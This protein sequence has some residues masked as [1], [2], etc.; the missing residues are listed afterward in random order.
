MPTPHSRSIDL[1]G[2]R[3]ARGLKPENT[4]PGFEVALD[5]G[6]SSIETD[7]HLTADGVPVLI[8]DPALPDGAPIAGLTLTQLR[9][10]RVNHNPDPQRFAQQDA[11]VTPLA[12]LFAEHHEIDPYAPP[13]VTDLFA[14]TVAYAGALGLQAGKSDPQRSRA[15]EVRFDLE[16]KRVPF[17][18]EYIGDSFQASAAG[19]LE[20]ALLDTIRAAGM[21]DRVRVRSFDHRCVRLLR[22]IEPRLS[23]GVLISGTAP[24]DPAALV[25]QADATR[26]CPDHEFLDEVQVQQCHAAGLLVVPWTVNQEADWQR[27]LAWGVDGLTTDYPDRLAQWLRQRGMGF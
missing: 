12:K 18:P 13:A 14:F 19:R 25:R 3:G 10:R 1:Q 5:L 6:V 11:S 16:L 2:H 4:L 21:L 17:H 9:G 27:L 20:T 15:S 26:Y 8:H 7:V 24:V 22:Q 23:A